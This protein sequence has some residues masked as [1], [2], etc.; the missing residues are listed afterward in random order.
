MLG[1]AKFLMSFRSPQQYIGPGSV[2]KPNFRTFPAGDDAGGII[3]HASKRVF[4]F[5]TNWSNVDASSDLDF[6]VSG[7]PLECY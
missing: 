1:P 4:V 6:F 2:A 3:D 7:V 5:D